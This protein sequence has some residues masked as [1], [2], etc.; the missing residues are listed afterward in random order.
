MFNRYDVLLLYRH[1]NMGI[2]IGEPGGIE[3]FSS[4]LVNRAVMSHQ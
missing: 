3:R 2:I 1:R 4:I